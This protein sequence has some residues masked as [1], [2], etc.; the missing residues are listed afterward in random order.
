MRH[1]S[2]SD[3]LTTTIFEKT[4]LCDIFAYHDDNTHAG[5]PIL[6]D[7]IMKKLFLFVDALDVSYKGHDLPLSQFGIVS[8]VFDT[9][10]TENALH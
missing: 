6:T 1:S 7:N 9:N 3:V 10:R 5:M 4:S 8:T 2:K